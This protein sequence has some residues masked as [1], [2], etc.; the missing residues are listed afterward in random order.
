MSPRL[1]AFLAVGALG[2]ALQ[3][4]AL[5][6]LTA[7]GWPVEPATA[8]AVEVAV[9]NNFWW[10]AR[11]TWGDRRSAGPIVLRLARYH[12]SVGIT[13]LAG[14]VLLTTWLVASLGLP[15]VAANL[16][17][18]AVM[19]AANFL[20]T[21]R[22]VFARRAALAVALVA[23]VVPSAAAASELKP[24][25]IAAWDRYVRAAED[26]LA[27]CRCEDGPEGTTVNVP[28]GTIHHWR[29][30]VFVRSATLEDVVQA[31]LY[32]GTPPPQDDVLESR[33]LSRSGDS[34]VVYLKL[35]RRAI[36][37][38]TYDTV[39]EVAFRRV[40]PRLATSRSVATRISEA[41]GRDRGFLWRLQSYW[42]YAQEDG[43]V[44]IHVDSLS[45]SRRI[46]AIARP[47]ASP[48]IT[49][50]ARESMSRTL[51]AVHRFLAAGRSRPRSDRYGR[52]SA[53][54][55]MPSASSAR[56][57]WAAIAAA[58]GVSPWTHTVSIARGRTD[59][60]RATTVRCR[61][62]RTTRAA[63]TAGSGITAPA[64]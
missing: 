37:T 46:P 27:A 63:T 60:S 62:M 25:T 23:I 34:L 22:W 20:V 28:D 19:A 8:A 56:R 59:P 2:F 26:R 61:T 57:R 6:A 55:A 33:V 64:V 52:S 44:R 18:V 12:A 13:A 51:Q 5:A 3:I 32:P 49:R 10:H 29:G 41:D 31:L 35:Q 4:A 45:L 50:I 11:W 21:D 54:T 36:V 40:N 7:V 9:L 17:A 30:S 1:T 43:G 42:R 14:N 38:V 39:H 24:E 58:P 53:L 15:P 48:I 16:A 47:V